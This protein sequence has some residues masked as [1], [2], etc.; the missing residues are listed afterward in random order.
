MTAQERAALWERLRN[1][2][3]FGEAFSPHFEDG[4]LHGAIHHAALALDAYEALK[5]DDESAVREALEWLETQW[6]LLLDHVT[7]GKLSKPYAFKDIESVVDDEITA[8]VNEAVK[9]ELAEA[10]NSRCGTCRWWDTGPF[11]TVHGL[12]I[13]LKGKGRCDCEPSE[14]HSPSQFYTADHGCPQWQRKDGAA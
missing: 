7:N 8:S 9:E 4:F 14:C 5:A 1:G 2:L 6:S 12:K 10:Q 13:E 11:V 3:N